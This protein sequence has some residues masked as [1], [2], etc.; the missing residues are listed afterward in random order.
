M[1]SE[2]VVG[3][4]N[5]LM[6]DVSFKIPAADAAANYL[7]VPGNTLVNWMANIAAVYSAYDK[8]VVK[9]T[10]ENVIWKKYAE[11]SAPAPG[12]FD[13]L[14]G[15]TEDPDK[16]KAAS[17][18]LVPTQP[19]AVPA[20]IA[21][22]AI[23]VT[24]T[25]SKAEYKALGGYGYPSAYMVVPVALNTVKPFGTLAGAG[26]LKTTAVAAGAPD[27]LMSVRKTANYDATGA[28][29]ITAC[30]KSYLMITGV[31]NLATQTKTVIL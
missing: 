16:P 15:A 28:T 7:K 5:N 2:P 17:S 26:I 22:L 10:A 20:T 14:C 31:V 24:A 3:Q 18:P 8:D 21:S 19:V 25:T 1:A 9:Y 27:S 6:G 11:Y 4:P 30:K 23:S 13:W 29:A 12:L